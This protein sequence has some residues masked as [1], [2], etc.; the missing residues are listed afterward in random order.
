MSQVSGKRKYFS[1]SHSKEGA[2]TSL[3]KVFLLRYCDKGTK[4]IHSDEPYAD[5]K[6]ALKA[7]TEYLKKGIC[8]WVVTYNE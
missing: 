2:A 3:K 7:L 5:E 4:T 6:Q 1:H 8:S